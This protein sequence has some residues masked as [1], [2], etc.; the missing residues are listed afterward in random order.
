MRQSIALRV[1][2]CLSRKASGFGSS[3]G[4][5]LLFAALCVGSSFRSISCVGCDFGFNLRFNCFSGN[6]GLFG[7]EHLVENVD[8]VLLQFSFV[9]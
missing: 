8:A 6:L 3:L 4:G 2:A 5:S 7:L 9:I 1:V